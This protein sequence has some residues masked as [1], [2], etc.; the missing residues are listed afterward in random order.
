MTKRNRRRFFLI[1][2]V[3][4]ALVFAWGYAGLAPAGGGASGY[5]DMV[6][7]VTVPLRH[8]TDAVTDV[9]FDI[10]GFDTLGEEFI[11]FASVMGV[12]LLMR[13][14]KD[15]PAGDHEDAARR[16]RVPHVSDAVRLTALLLIAPT[17]L[18]G[19]YIVTHGQVSPGG[20]F[21]GGV[22]L[23]TAPVL[24][25]LASGYPKFR[26]IVHPPL[27]EAAEAI[28]AAA[29]IIVGGACVMLGGLF[30]ENL[31]PLGKSGTVTGGGTIAFIDLGVGAEVSGGLLL[32]LLV[33]LEEL[34]E[35]KEQ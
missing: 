3:L 30:L 17:V 8:T 31:L 14:Q 12:V 22:I 35:E 27:V 32:A 24:V 19:L 2:A 10:R 1:S 7:S 16:R 26:R 15:E 6:N 28:G 21:Q 34:M 20:G 33:Y 11:L 9:N 18:F 23:S 13:R 29:Y 5:G 25:Y 4:L